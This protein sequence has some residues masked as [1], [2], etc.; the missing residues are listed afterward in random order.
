MPVTLYVEFV[1]VIVRDRDGSYDPG[2][3]SHCG[4]LVALL[5]AT[6]ALMYFLK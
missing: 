6:V 2:I 3:P 1:Q 5:F 4:W